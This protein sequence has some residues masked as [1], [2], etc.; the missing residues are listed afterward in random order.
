MKP[1]STSLS[2]NI[3][4]D[5]I[6]LA[7]KML[8]QFWKWKKGEAVMVLEE[9]FRKYL[10]IKYAFAFNS[11][12][13]ALMAILDSLEIRKGDEILIQAFTCNAAVNSIL[14]A[15]VKPVFVD[16]DQTI[17]MDPEDLK[18]KITPRAKA[19]M[20]QHT[21]GW[22]ARIDRVKEIAQKHNL[23]LIE[24]CAHSLGAEY[25][26]GKVGTFGEMAFFSF[27]RDKVISSVFGG[28]AA[29]N[30]EQIAE[31]IKNFQ[32]KISYPS[33]FWI[34]QQLLHPVLVNYFVLPAYGISSWLGTAVLGALHKFFI[35]SKAVYK[36]E[37][38]GEIA[39][40]FPKKMP[41]VLALLA[42]NQFGKLER[43]NKHRQAIA[44]LYQKNLEG[45]FQMPLARRKDVALP[46]FMKFPVLV[47]E[48]TDA[49]LKKARKKKIYLNDGWRKTPIVPPDVDIKKT[50]YQWGSCPKAERMARKIIN[51]PTHINISFRKAEKIIKF[52]SQNFN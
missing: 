22:P 50:R 16:I 1:I 11:G 20:V 21:F 52:L 18:K 8:F 30:D 14:A 7:F 49:I 5:D 48:E 23:Y 25:K 13:S 37:K 27:G 12:R 3:E 42:L 2:P 43:F 33:S 10:G 19:V 51:L 17:N 45:K 24:D 34:F 15:G 4:K 46:I 40:Y 29:V 44:D 47:E 41:N 26:G 32:K 36:E 31:K 9:K 6:W 35:L 39:C 38:R 28:I